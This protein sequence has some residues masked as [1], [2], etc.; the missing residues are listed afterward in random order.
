MFKS[1]AFV[2]AFVFLVLLNLGLGV[3]LI[4]L[5]PRGN[6]PVD[7]FPTNTSEQ[8]TLSEQTDL[9][10]EI[11][12]DSSLRVLKEDEAHRYPVLSEEIE[13]K[14]VL[15]V[16]ESTA[17]GVTFHAS[18]V[19]DDANTKGNIVNYRGSYDIVAKV[20]VN[21][22]GKPYL[23]YKTDDGYYVTSNKTYVTYKTQTLKIPED[24]RKVAV[25]GKADGHKI[26][27]TVH[28]ED[29]IHLAFSLNSHDGANSERLLSNVIAAYDDAGTA[30][31]E[32]A[33][34]GRVIEGSVRFEL[35]DT[36]SYEATIDF[37]ESIV[38]LGETLREVTLSK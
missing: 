2:I 11:A 35:N 26:L 19:F 38:V 23:M 6:S 32:Y 20:F 4:V 24:K 8:T 12:E 37:G 15:S 25:Y 29:G 36:G 13:E 22:N 34:N 21:D 14:G 31:F 30:H 17:I 27:L 5:L 9:T 10:E 18:P 7:F 28:Q 3:F 16:N 33:A 1:K